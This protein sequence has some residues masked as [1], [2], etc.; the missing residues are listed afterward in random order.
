M[1]RPLTALFFVVAIAT[2]QHVQA[3]SNDKYTAELRKAIEVAVKE[4]LKDPNSAIIK[5]KYV[6]KSSDITGMFA[7]ECN[8]KNS[9]GGYVGFRPFYG[10]WVVIKGKT[11]AIVAGISEE[12]SYEQIEMIVRRDQ[13]KK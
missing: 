1:L 9:Y 4:K 5:I 2:P 7:G 8:A 12:L 3:D 11:S 10:G 13:A 6:K